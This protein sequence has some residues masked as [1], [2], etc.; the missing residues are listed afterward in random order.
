[1]LYFIAQALGVLSFVGGS[2][3]V[4]VAAT[5]HVVSPPVALAQL[6]PQAVAEWTPVLANAIVAISGA[7]C[8]VY[9]G[10]Q[11]ARR[12]D[13]TADADIAA[14]WRARFEEAQ[15][16]LQAVTAERDALKAKAQA[17]VE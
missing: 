5:G 16:Q 17:K 13:A 4:A 15:A 2:A 6:E 9:A 7:L 1:M 14:N 11:R 10:V 3:A 12:G 8:A